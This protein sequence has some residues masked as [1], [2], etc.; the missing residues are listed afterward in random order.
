LGKIVF[1]FNIIYI[2]SAPF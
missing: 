2:N 1:I